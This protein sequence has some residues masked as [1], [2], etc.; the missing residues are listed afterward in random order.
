MRISRLLRPR[1]KRDPLAQT[2]IT[3]AALVMFFA[4]ALGTHAIPYWH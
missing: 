1:G 4:M 3:L 2:M